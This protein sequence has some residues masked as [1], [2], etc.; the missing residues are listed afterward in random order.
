MARIGLKDTIVDRC[1][2]TGGFLIAALAEMDSRADGDPDIRE[3]IRR[4]RLIGVEQQP[5]MFALAASNMILRGDGKANLFQGS[6]FDPDIIA[7]LK[8]PY[9]KRFQP[10]TIGLINPP[11]SQQGEG[12]HEWNFVAT[13]LDILR[14]G[15]RAVVV[16]PMSCAIEPNAARTEIL[17]N[18]TLVASISLPID[19]FLGA[20]MC[21]LVFETLR[22]LRIFGQ[23]DKLKAN[24]SKGA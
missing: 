8:E 17:K 15:G 10:P 18:H 16:L 9:K 14:P 11:F 6:C 3:D 21:A 4:H 19:L 13:L 2:D 1:C 7:K 24:R 5:Q 20:I 12:L 22:R 23:R